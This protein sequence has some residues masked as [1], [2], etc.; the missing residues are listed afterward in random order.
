MFCNVSGC[1]SGS[2]ISAESERKHMELCNEI[3]GKCIRA[4]GIVFVN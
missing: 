4:H 3:L 1:E 2:V